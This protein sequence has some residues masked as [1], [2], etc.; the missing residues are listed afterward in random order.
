MN[1]MAYLSDINGVSIYAIISLI[2]FFAFF[3]GLFVWVS[4]MSKSSVDECKQI[5]LE[6][7]QPIHSTSNH[8]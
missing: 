3:I 7:N 2:I 4:R 1:F 5:P 6:D 8:Q